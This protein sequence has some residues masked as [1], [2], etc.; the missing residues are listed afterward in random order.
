MSTEQSFDRAAAVA[1]FLVLVER[2]SPM[3][4]LRGVAASFGVF[5][6]EVSRAVMSAAIREYLH[7]LGL[8]HEPALEVLIAAAKKF[9]IK[10][11][12]LQAAVDEHLLSMEAP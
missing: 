11:P 3:D 2:V 8:T 5:P 9:H 1:Q 7:A 4:A 6:G 10:L 12:S